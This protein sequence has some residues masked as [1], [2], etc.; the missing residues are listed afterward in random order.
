MVT[1]PG[2]VTVDTEGSGGLAWLMSMIF[3]GLN[4]VIDQFTVGF[5]EDDGG[6]HDIDGGVYDG[7]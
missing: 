6:R 5:E 3:P 2:L 1:W 4:E 7:I